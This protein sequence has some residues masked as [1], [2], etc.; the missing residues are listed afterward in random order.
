MKAE[1]VEQFRERHTGEYSVFACVQP[2]LQ[3][4][5]MRGQSHLFFKN[6]GDV[7]FA[8]IKKCSQFIKRKVIFQMIVDIVADI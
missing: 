3:D 7:I 6:M 1:L 2:F 4:I 5:L 8:D